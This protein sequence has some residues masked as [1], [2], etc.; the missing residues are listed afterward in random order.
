V[1]TFK[2]S[3]VR[4]TGRLATSRQKNASS[5]LQESAQA[6]SI[7]K[8]YDIFLSHSF[9]DAELILGVKIKLENYGYSVY[10]DWLEDPQLNRSNITFQTA[11]KLRERMKCCQSLF[12][13]TT[14][15]SSKSKWMPWE[16]G[17]IDG[18]RGRSAILP[19]TETGSGTYKGQEYLG[20]YP[21]ITEAPIKGQ[22]SKTLW[23]NQSVDVYCKFSDWL[24][25]KM[26]QQ[27]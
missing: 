16:C 25:G 15:A 8:S 4:S 6:Q 1:S 19:L 10:V 2:I 20:I 13:S 5:V 21:Y 23:V 22:T 24:K 17:Y 27:H 14:E 18:L 9:R 26:P 7:K 3:E 12:Y 11:T